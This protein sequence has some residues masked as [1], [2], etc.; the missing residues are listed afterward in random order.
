MMLAKEENGRCL[1][2]IKETFAIFRSIK[3]QV[4]VFKKILFDTV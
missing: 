2:N 3:F 1:S 4:P